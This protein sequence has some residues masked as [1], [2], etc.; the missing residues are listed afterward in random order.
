MK[1]LIIT[2]YPKESDSSILNVEFADEFKRDDVIFIKDL[3]SKTDFEE[4]LQ[5]C[6]G[7]FDRVVVNAHGDKMDIPVMFVFEGDFL[8]VTDVIKMINKGN[9][10]TLKKI[11]LSS[12]HIG[13]NFEEIEKRE[14]SNQYY[15]ELE[16]SLIDGQM[17]FMHGDSY[18]GDVVLS[19]DQRLKGIVENKDYS[20][21]EAVFDSAEVVSVVI[22]KHHNQTDS[23]SLETFSYQ[24]FA[25]NCKAEEFTTA[26]LRTYLNEVVQ[27]A[28]SFEEAQGIL[29]G[30]ASKHRLENLSEEDLLKYL[31]KRFII[32][33]GKAGASEDTEMVEFLRTI[34]DPNLVTKDGWTALMIAADQ[35]D[36]K[37]VELLLENE[38]TDPNLADK[39]GWTALMSAAGKGDTETLELLLKN[40]KT[41]PNLP[42][43]YGW[44]ALMIAAE[45]GHTETLELLLKKADIFAH[46]DGLTA[47][48][49]A[50]DNK[51]SE[52]VKILQNQEQLQ[53]KLATAVDSKNLTAVEDLIN[54]GANPNLP[55]SGAPEESIWTPLDRAADDKNVPMME[56]LLEKGAAPKDQ[57]AF[58]RIAKRVGD[59]GD[60]VNKINPALELLSAFT[61]YKY[62]RPSVPIDL[63]VMGPTNSP[64]ASDDHW[65][66]SLPTP[67]ATPTF[68][69]TPSFDSPSPSWPPAEDWHKH[70]PAAPEAPSFD[71]PPLPPENA[72]GEYKFTAGGVDYVLRY[73]K[74]SN[75]SPAPATEV[76]PTKAQK[77][78]EEGAKK[79]GG[80]TT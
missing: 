29:N 60:F 30:N 20:L 10:K 3:S 44:T 36:T 77:V 61:A 55:A 23:A 80:K 14:S 33:V 24:S 12:C 79:T 67:S 11:H 34:S 74:E 15:L 70:L 71:Y 37:I 47:L 2:N 4:R 68:S 39:D 1:T 45:K 50:K 57:E 54:R 66:E 51:N 13:F 46:K 27:K 40:E 17:L 16:E 69:A 22:K 28:R 42:D 65:H 73:P 76:N 58:D 18:I 48:K 78:S 9:E 64:S 53:S 41:N 31:S 38:K 62:G 8:G 63:N 59:V 19:L 43:K 5:S 35:G 56:L 52:V 6:Q 7:E 72:E 75:D 32:E 49:V 25:R 26:N 21:S